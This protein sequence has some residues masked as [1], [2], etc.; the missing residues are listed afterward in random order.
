MLKPKSL[1]SIERQLSSKKTIS[2]LQSQLYTLQ[3]NS[4]TYSSDVFIK[5]SSEAKQIVGLDVSYL[6]G[7]AYWIPKYDIRSETVDGP[8]D[9]TYKADV[10]QSTGVDWK[11]VKLKL[12]TGNPSV[13][14]TQPELDSWHL[15][16]YDPNEFEKSGRGRKNYSTAYGWEGADN[17]NVYDYAD[18]EEDAIEEDETL[19][20]FDAAPMQKLELKADKDRYAEQLSSANTA[21]MNKSNVSTEFDIV[22]PYSIASDGQANVVEIQ[23]Y[24]LPC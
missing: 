21:M 18:V 9:L 10:F 6:V 3:G 20:L 8:I 13:D 12:S 2:R 11:N 23:K 17:N 22:L 15:S 14:N 19:A 7:K 1:T 24:K 16:Y 4:G 5:V